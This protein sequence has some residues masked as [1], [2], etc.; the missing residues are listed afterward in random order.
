MV[1]R[2]PVFG[3]AGQVAEKIAGVD[4][5]GRD[6][7]PAPGVGIR[8]GPPGNQVPDPIDGGLCGQ[9]Q[10]AGPVLAMRHLLHDAAMD[11]TTQVPARF[12]GGWKFSS[13]H[14][15]QLCASP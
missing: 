8:L 9:N 4:G 3:Q 7:R 1:T 12:D 5:V 6:L 14:G 15:K 10:L 2:V 11:V 13:L